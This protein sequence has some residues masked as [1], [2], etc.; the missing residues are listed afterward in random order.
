PWTTR[1]L[2]SRPSSARRAARRRTVVTHMSSQRA[3]CLA[4]TAMCSPAKRMTS[5]SLSVIRNPAPGPNAPPCL[6]VV[7][8]DRRL[9]DLAP[10]DL[11]AQ[12]L[13]ICVTD[14]RALLAASFLFFSPPAGARESLSLLLLSPQSPPF[15]HLSV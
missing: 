6:R 10:A 14:S 2:A 9:R 13:S 15:G 5:S 11:P 1:C 7:P 8:M 3:T 4:S 12:P